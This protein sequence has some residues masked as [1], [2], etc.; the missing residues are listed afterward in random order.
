MVHS[1]TPVFF[2]NHRALVADDAVGFADGRHFACV[3]LSE[4]DEWLV[5][6]EVYAPL[7]L[8]DAPLAKEVEGRLQDLGGLFALGIFFIVLGFILMS[9]GGSDDPNIFSDEI[10]NFTRIRL[11]PALIL[12]G[13]AIQVYAILKSS[14]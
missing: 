4:V 14:K 6:S 9:G 7:Q 5:L 10:Y 11:A 12:I 3:A 1:I 13:F 2:V 8:V